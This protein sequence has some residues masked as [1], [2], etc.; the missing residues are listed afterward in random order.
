MN[1]LHSNKA[2]VGRSPNLKDVMFHAHGIVV[3]YER[4]L[5]PSLFRYSFDEGCGNFVLGF[6]IVAFSL[7]S[8]KGSGR[9]LVDTELSGAVSYR[10]L[11]SLKV[12]YSAQLLLLY[13]PIVRLCLLGQYL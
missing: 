4:R 3:Q 10:L 5:S 6:Y 11:C 8:P 1:R 12:Q 7:D 9:G 2:S 13:S